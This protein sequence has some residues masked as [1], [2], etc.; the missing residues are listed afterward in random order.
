MIA[1]YSRRGP[2]FAGFAKPDMTAYAGTITP[3]GVPR[4]PYSLVLTN[5][6]SLTTDCGTSFSAPLVAGDLAEITTFLPT[7]DVFLAKALMYHTAL[8]LWDNDEVNEDDLITLHQW[9]GRGLS[10]VTDSKFSQPHKVTFMRTGTLNRVTKEHV[11]IFMPSILAA[12]TGR[13]IAKV[14]V[15]CLSN[16]PVDRTKSSEYL[17]AYVRVSLKKAGENGR[18]LPVSQDQKEGRR[19]W[20]ICH[21]FTKTF[22]SFNAGDWEIWLELF[23][24][25]ENNDNDVPYALVVTIEDMS[26]T[27][28][29][30]NEIE[31]LNRYQA[32]IPVRVQVAQ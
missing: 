5:T 12:Q 28:D 6:N 9:Y 31:T 30:Y 18:L 29:I 24:R 23:S 3:A 8:P 15:T 11:K 14:S 20:D 10:C 17:K 21:Q 25:W 32:A 2:G 1:P 13:N 16:P 27:V 19:K 7:P 4:D 26:K 22:S